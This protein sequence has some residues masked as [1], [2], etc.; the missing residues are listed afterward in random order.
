MADMDPKSV[1]AKTL[2]DWLRSGEAVLVDVREP[3]EHAAEHI[4]GA[5]LLPLGRVHA[6]ALPPGRRVVVHC[7][8]GGRGAAA[9][10]ALLA[11]NPALEIYNLEGG[12]AAWRDAGYPVARS[13]RGLLPLDRQVQLT[14]GLCLIAASALAWLVTPLF[15]ALTLFF[16]LGLTLAGAT[17]FCGLARLIARMPWNQRSA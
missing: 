5:A 11:E 10:H 12:I 13:G 3:G 15:L 6:H 17:G 8:R 1:D 9:C 2:K 7:A 14:I 4:A 16:G